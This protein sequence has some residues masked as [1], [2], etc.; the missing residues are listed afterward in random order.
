M[1]EQA[2]QAQP[3]SLAKKV[4]IFVFLALFLAVGAYVV[5]TGG[6]A[7]ASSQTNPRL[8]G[9]AF[10]AFAVAFAL[11]AVWSWRNPASITIAGDHVRC[12]RFL[13]AFS[14]SEER[15][16]PS[17]IVVGDI[18]WSFPGATKTNQKLQ[19]FYL[20]LRRGGALC[21]RYPVYEKLWPE[22]ARLHASLRRLQ[23]GPPAA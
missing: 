13:S 8:V 20:E 21:V 1:E 5:V 7:P 19:L 4:Y 12:V 11:A 23:G 16:A 3:P 15:F 10:V 6:R 9:A 14:A 2:F 18:Q 17:E 22:F